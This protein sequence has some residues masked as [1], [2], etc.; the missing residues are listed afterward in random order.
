MCKTYDGLLTVHYA[1]PCDDL[2]PCFFSE[3]II[4]DKSLYVVTQRNEVLIGLGGESE[5]VFECA[6]G[7][8]FSN[9]LT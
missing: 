9:D 6:Y 4:V 8:N 2:T 7:P 3:Y 5:R 1:I